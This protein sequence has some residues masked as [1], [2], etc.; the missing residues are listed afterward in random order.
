[1]LAEHLIKEAQ[2]ATAL[3][4]LRSLIACISAVSYEERIR[5]LNTT[6]AHAD[7]SLCP[8]CRIQPAV[9]RAASAWASTCRR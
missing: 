4:D 3:D 8:S 2:K 5:Y 6:R 1:M 9:G 7:T